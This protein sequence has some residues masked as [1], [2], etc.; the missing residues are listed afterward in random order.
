[1]APTPK[2][3]DEMLRRFAALQQEHTHYR[4]RANNYGCFNVES[5]RNCNFVYNSRN[6]IGCH[7]S[8]GL[9]DC[10]QCVDCRS[11][12]FCVGL[13]GSAYAILNEEYTEEQYYALLTELGVDWQVEVD[14]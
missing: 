13:T 4:D 10:L 3:M 12:A 8:D 11:C 6:A 2:T 14:A 7:A 1:M 9:I 5:C